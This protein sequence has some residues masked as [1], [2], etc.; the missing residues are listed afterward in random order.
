MKIHFEFLMFHLYF[1][2]V[3]LKKYFGYEQNSYNLCRHIK[4]RFI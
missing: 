1:I 2:F 4:Q 3:E